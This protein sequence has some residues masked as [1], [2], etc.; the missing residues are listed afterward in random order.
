M[1]MTS[2]LKIVSFNCGG[3]ANILPVISD[4][5]D[6]NDVIVLQETWL[7]PLNIDLFVGLH[8]EF[9]CHSITS[10]DLC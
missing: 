7:T 2:Q 3:V 1:I 9:D 8:D 6:Q 5:C 10:V 4:L